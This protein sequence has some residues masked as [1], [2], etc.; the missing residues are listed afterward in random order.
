MASLKLAGALQGLGEGIAK[1]GEE[2]AQTAREIRLQE[3]RNAGQLAGQKEANVGAMA[4]QTQAQGEEQRRRD[5]DYFRQYGVMPPPAGTPP[6]AAAAPVA[7]V[8]PPP[9]PPAAGPP[10]PPPTA[11]QAPADQTPYTPPR[12]GTS[13]VEHQREMEKAAATAAARQ[14]RG[15]GEDDTSVV[16][17]GGGFGPNGPI[18]EEQVNRIV[19]KDNQGNVTGVYAMDPSNGK[20][21]PFQFYLFKANGGLGVVDPETGISRPTPA[22]LLYENPEKLPDYIKKYNGVPW[23]FPEIFPEHMP[24]GSEPQANVL[25]PP[26]AEEE[27]AS[28]APGGGM[29]SQAAGSMQIPAMGT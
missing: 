7:P 5:E 22:G 29:L 12:A 9:G 25:P 18:P 8:A 15:Y 19:E 17:I 3:L 27:V 2:K 20:K 13:E 6:P 21:V 26:G 11:P 14:A 4:R 28:V 23:W 10:A 1:R 16:T 24:K